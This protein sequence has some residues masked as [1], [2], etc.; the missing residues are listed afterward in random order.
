MPQT[1]EEKKIIETRALIAARKAGVPIPL[2]ETP[3]EEPD[4]LFDE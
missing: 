2:G 3:S 4:F 1:S